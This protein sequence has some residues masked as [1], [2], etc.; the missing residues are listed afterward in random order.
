MQT[1]LER[2]ATKATQDATC[3]FTSLMHHLKPELLGASLRV[4][5]RSS[6]PGVDDEEVITARETFKD[7]SGELIRQ[8]HQ[9]GYRPPPVKRIYIPKPGKKA[10]RP[11]GI[12]TV[13]DRVLQRSLSTIL[14][15]IYEADF[16]PCSHGGRPSRSAHNAVSSVKYT[17]SSRKISW[18]Y[19]ADLKNFFGSLDH[20]WLMRFVAHRVKDPR[21]LTL[22][23]RWLK[24]G[25]MEEKMYHTSEM[26][27]PQGGSISVLL[28]NV[29][30]HYVLDL[31]FDKKV[32]PRLQGEAHLCRYLD[33]FVVCFQL[34][35]D[36]MAFEDALHERLRKFKLELEPSKTQLLPFGR[37]SK[38]DHKAKGKKAPTFEFLG[39]TFYGSHFKAGNY[40]VGLKTAKSRL[41]R[42]MNAL[43]IKL[44]RMRHQPLRVQLRQINAHLRGHY[45]Y[46]G[47]PFN[48]RSLVRLYRYAIKMWRK[49]LGRRSQKGRL[50]WVKYATILKY[51]PP[52]KPRL[53][54]NHLN[55]QLLMKG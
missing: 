53:R 9:Q 28:S 4:I 37:F 22:I 42:S 41:N 27:T 17:I 31:W 26:G 50:T 46:Y 13:R 1:G 19:E 52:I 45:Q 54:Y 15:C 39:F 3:C 7:W 48:S 20:G 44:Q 25:V 32:K 30:L 8:V 29:Y 2:I 43:K 21:V 16:L 33:D 55:F 14:S 18:V 34:K 35:D 40:T 11:I 5:K 49:S 6:S 23:R 24:A 47:V 38:R 36:A 51:C 12:P 10:L